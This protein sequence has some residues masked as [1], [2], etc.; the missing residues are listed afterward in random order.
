VAGF[1]VEQPLGPR[2]PCDA[3]HDSER[4]ACLLE[5]RPLF[6]VQLEERR[7][8]LATFDER[9]TTGAAALLVA[10]S[11]GC[12]SP[13][14]LDGLD[15]GDHPERAV[16]FATRG[17]G[18]EMR[19]GPD[20]VVPGAPDQIAGWVDLDVEPGLAHP[21]GRELVGPI[22]LRAAADPVRA[23]AA[24]DRVELVEPF[25]NALRVYRPNG[26]NG[27]GDVETSTLFVSR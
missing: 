18:I 19:P 17:H 14:A 7:R 15:R 27:F 8:Q 13:N 1:A 2:H 26:L 25:E 12:T 24:A 11:D 6:D 3:G 5:Y 4:R 23:D 20:I 21:P 10:E 22:L 9:R 16:E